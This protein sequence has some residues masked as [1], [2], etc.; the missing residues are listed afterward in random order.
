MRCAR[1]P[2][3]G[4]GTDLGIREACPEL[5]GLRKGERDLGPPSG[6]FPAEGPIELPNMSVKF[7]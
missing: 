7:P 2:G 5:S 6:D 4:P 3:G 1:C